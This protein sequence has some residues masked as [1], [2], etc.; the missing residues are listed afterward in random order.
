MKMSAAKVTWIDAKYPLFCHECGHQWSAV[1][2]YEKG[3]NFLG[4][5]DEKEATCSLCGHDADIVH[6]CSQ[7]PP[8]KVLI[9]DRD[10]ID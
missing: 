7:C 5:K 6:G 10:E 3:T 9:D 4:F 1:V 2:F 8:T